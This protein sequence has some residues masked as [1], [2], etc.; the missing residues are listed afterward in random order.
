MIQTNRPAPRFSLLAAAA[1]AV[2]LAGAATDAL[3]QVSQLQVR[4]LVRY[5]QVSASEVIPRPTETYW[6]QADV[7]GTNI[8][9]ITPPTISG[10]IDTAS[11]GAQHN[12]GT[13]V[14][15]AADAGWR[16]GTGARDFRTTSRSELDRIFGSGTY[17]FTVNGTSVPLTLSGDAYPNA[18]MVTLTGGRW[19][20]GAYV[21]DPAQP[22][23]ITTNAF[24]GYGT[25]LNDVICIFFRGTGFVGPER[26]VITNCPYR[27]QRASDVP[28][29]SSMTVTVPP[30]SFAADEEYILSASF[31]AITESRNAAGLPGS[32]NTARYGAQTLV[33]VKSTTPV[34]A[35]TVT[36]N[37]NA[38]SATASAAIQFRPQDVGTTASVYVF[39]VAPADLVRP[40]VAGSAF[41]VG[42]AR[43]TADGKDTSVACVLAQLNASGQLQA[44]STSSLQAY[45]TGVLSSQGQAV[46]IMNGVPTVNVGGATFYVGYGTSSAAMISSGVN[47]SAV[48]VPGSRECRPQ[49]PQKGWWWN[50]GESGRGYSIEVQGNNLFM[51]TYLY[52]VSGRATWHV[53]AGPTS[54]DG[55]VFNGQLLSFGNGVTLTG[56]YRPN[57][58]LADAG[59]VTLT[60]D[61]ADRGTLVWPGGTVAIQRFGFGTNGPAT[62]AL[63]DQPESGWWWG[64]SGDDGR[65][66]FIEWQ[67]NQAFVAGYM[68]D[69]AGNP[70]WYVAQGAVSNA[71]SFAGSWMQFANGQSMNGAYRVPSMVNGNVAPLAIQF[72]GADAATLTLPSGTL[73]IS[74]FRF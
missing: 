17:T 36:S 10:P 15:N 51:A 62:A 69:A 12:N 64:G 26:S 4:K 32:S 70:V 39:A 56:P 44:V 31:T 49:P 65:G 61:D 42:T 72:Q 24:A 28:G 67:G 48:T 33:R 5:S 13:L 1:A 40:A 41:K 8:A 2:A 20:D 22:L 71:Q 45:V 11:L 73:P 23:T 53:A 18:P 30:N 9:G 38:V 46:S 19:A 59:P 27:L 3:A 68:Y 55:S 57:A 35:M 16:W 6:F 66:F 74:R 29:S 52:D 50:P 43:A 47:R 34:F 21:I 60:F 58:R 25:H 63:A 54:L 14:Y 37:I 7:D